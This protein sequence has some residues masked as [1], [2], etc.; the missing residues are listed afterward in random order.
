MSI[1]PKLQYLFRTLPL[2]L[3]PAYFKAVH[4]DMTKF[5][6]AGS[7]PRVAMKVLC[8]P[9]KAGGLAVPDIEAYFHASVLA[10]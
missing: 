7:R 4:K 2:Q 1:L 6:W 8:A 10:S 9:T 5:I 3:P